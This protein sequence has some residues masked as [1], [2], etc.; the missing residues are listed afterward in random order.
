MEISD[1]NDHLRLI[2]KHAVDFL[3]VLIQHFLLGV[4]AE[5]LRANISSK[6]ANSLQ[7]G[8]IDPKFHVEEVA[9]PR[10]IF[11]LRKLG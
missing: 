8:P 6:S 10:T 5:A 4:T 2:E 9:P 11:L 1:Y 7:L 3:L